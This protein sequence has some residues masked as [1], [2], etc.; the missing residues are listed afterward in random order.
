[1]NH[2]KSILV[3]NFKS[4]AI[5]DTTTW[6]VKAAIVKSHVHMKKR[7]TH[8]LD[9]HANF[10]ALRY[11]LYMLWLSL[12]SSLK[13]VR[14]HLSLDFFWS[15]FH[16]CS[17]HTLKPASISHILFILPQLAFDAMCFA[18]KSLPCTFFPCEVSKG[19]WQTKK[20]STIMAVKAKCICTWHGKFVM[21]NIVVLA[22]IFNKFCSRARATHMYDQRWTPSFLLA[23]VLN[24]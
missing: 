2:T 12:N 13:A 20:K 3:Y 5:L 22:N 10:I 23:C 17:T 4:Y 8:L 18:S 9:L 11:N 15:P 14:L 21:C 24:N 6:K 19:R 7:R 1:M 16:I